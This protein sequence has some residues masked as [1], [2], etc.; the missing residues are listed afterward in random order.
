MLLNHKPFKVNKKQPDK[1]RRSENQIES[2]YNLS[3][4]DEEIKAEINS[5]QQEML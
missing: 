5:S 1:L 2:F 4:G 3:F